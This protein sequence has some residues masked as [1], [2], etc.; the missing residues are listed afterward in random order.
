MLVLSRKTG[1]GITLADN[2]T[3]RV[4]SVR[5][6]RVQLAIEAPKWVR[7]RRQELS[8]PSS[9]RTKPPVI[10]TRAGRLCHLY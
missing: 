8:S 1:E 3:V 6:G 4:V 9:A 10:R 2:I 7:I 5:G